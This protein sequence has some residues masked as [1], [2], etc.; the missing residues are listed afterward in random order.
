MW[1]YTAILD[2]KDKV[3]DIIDVVIDEVATSS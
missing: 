3:L 1:W 2:T